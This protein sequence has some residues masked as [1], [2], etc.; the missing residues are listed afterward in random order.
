MKH[1]VRFYSYQEEYFL[2][3]MTLW[4]QQRTSNPFANFDY[5]T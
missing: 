4:Q 5:F 2:R 1:A 3:K